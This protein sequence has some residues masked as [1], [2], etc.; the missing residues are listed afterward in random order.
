MQ[1]AD[2]AIVYFNPKTIAHKKLETITAQQVAKAFGGDNITVYTDS[3]KVIAD[4]LQND[5]TNTNVLVMSSG[6]F[7]G[8]NLNELAEKIT[9]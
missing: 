8:V 6:N 3:E 5:F 4:L 2:K 7:S 9:N 1:L